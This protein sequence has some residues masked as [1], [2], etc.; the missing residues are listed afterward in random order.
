MTRSMWLPT[1]IALTATACGADSGEPE[2]T[3]AAEPLIINNTQVGFGAPG[4]SYFGNTVHLTYTG[5][6]RKLNILRFPNGPGAPAQKI[7][8]EEKSNYGSTLWESGGQLYLA[9]VGLDGALNMLRSSDG[10]FFRPETKRTTPVVGYSGEPSLVF[11]AGFL[12]A[13]VRGETTVNGS[14]MKQWGIINDEFEDWGSVFETTNSS[15]SAAILGN[16]LVLAWLCSDLRLCTKKHS[17]TAGWLTTNAVRIDGLPHVWTASIWP[18]TLMMAFRR[19]G[20]IGPKQIEFWKTT[21]TVNWQFVNQVGHTTNVRPFGL[22]A[23]SSFVEYIHRGTDDRMN[24]N[25]FNL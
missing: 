6:D 5:T 18:P 14:F 11:Y 9:W 23:N 17:Q 15:P 8:L 13:W 22:A 20:Q 3:R 10:S 25:S 1:L 7:T 12:R 16:E 19:S 4:G 24:W 2:V 21:D